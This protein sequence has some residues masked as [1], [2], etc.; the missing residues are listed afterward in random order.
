M[1]NNRYFQY[2]AGERKGEIVFFDKIETEDDM[3]FVCFKDKSRCNEELIVPLNDKNWEGKLM[4]EISDPSNSWKMNTEWIGKIEEKWEKNGDGVPVCIQPAAAG[5]KKT[6]VFPPR[7]TKA[8]FGN[9]AA[10]V[11][12]APPTKQEIHKNDPV[13]IMM[14]KSKKFDT[15]IPM[16]ITISLPSK[17]LFNVA[18]ESFEDGGEKVIEYI[19]DNLD[20]TKLKTNLKDA[21]L[22]TYQEAKINS[23]NE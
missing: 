11:P 7:P 22:L 8:K 6:N 1:D 13:W 15:L 21:L 17:S 16:E 2:L 18:E 14:A 5:R 23:N 4:A 19:I 20:D 9:F 10:P 12:E 3:I